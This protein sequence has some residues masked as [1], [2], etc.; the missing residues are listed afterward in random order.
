M[1][2]AGAH[3]AARLDLATFADM[4][5]ETSEVLVIHMLD[6]IDSEGG[7]L[8]PGR[9]APSATRTATTA[10]WSSATRTFA[11]AAASTRPLALGPTEA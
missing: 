4:T 2:G 3:L 6:V 10:A 8:A 9:I 1:L 5:A 7:N 11:L